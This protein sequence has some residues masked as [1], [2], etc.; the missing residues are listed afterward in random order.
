MAKHE[1]KEVPASQGASG[2]AIESPTGTKVTTGHMYEMTKND[3][4]ASFSE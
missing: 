3:E 1:T 2:P 4:S